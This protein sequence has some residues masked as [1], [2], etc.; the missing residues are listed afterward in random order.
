MKALALTLFALA[1]TSC[2]KQG[3]IDKDD[4]GSVPP[5]SGSGPED[6]AAL[7]DSSPPG[8]SGAPEDTGAPSEPEPEPVCLVLDFDVDADGQ[9]ILAGQDLA[10]AY[11][12]WGVHIATWD[13]GMVHPGLGIAF[14]SSSPPGTDYDLGTPNEAYGGP[15]VG[16]AGAS[17]DEALFNLLIRAESTTDADGD[18]LVDVPDD[19]VYGGTFVITLDAPWCV[20]ALDLIDVDEAA[21][22]LLLLGDGDAELMNVVI[23]GGGDNARET[24]EPDT[25]GVSKA[26]LTLAG[27]GG[28]DGILLCEEEGDAGSAPQAR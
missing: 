13:Q 2:S 14:D 3:R 6:S 11:A 24:L 19:H 25:C 23:P 10:E 26:V 18:G 4:T 7:E 22:S 27:S 17:N 5:D 28:V 9:A 16:S 15:G 1:L 21:A 12:S 8:D 20:L